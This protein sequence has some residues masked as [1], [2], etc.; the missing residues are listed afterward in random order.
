MADRTV[1]YKGK[2][3]SASTIKDFYQRLNALRALNG[4]NTSIT[5]VTPSGNIYPSVISNTFSN[6]LSTKSALTFLASVNIA[7]FNPVTP[8]VG[9]VAKTPENISRLEY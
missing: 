3:I 8:T 6:I 2:K 5:V 9:I 7:S 4:G 1:T